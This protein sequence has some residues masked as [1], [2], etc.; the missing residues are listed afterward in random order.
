MIV[1]FVA[2][3]SAAKA[4]LEAIAEEFSFELAP[5]GIESV[6]LEPG[7]YGTEAFS[8]LI[9]P[10][11]DKALAGYG[12]MATKPQE[13]FAREA[14]LVASPGAPDPQEVADAVK[15]LIE[16]PAGQRP[17][18]TVVGSRIVAGVESLN[19][20]YEASKQEMLASLGAA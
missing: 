4:A 16:M 20:A 17:L 18:R 6:I 3:Y 14:Q 7:S 10:T 15:K 9:F 5:F 11:D 13:M 1:P 19:R 2:P 8:K 12:E